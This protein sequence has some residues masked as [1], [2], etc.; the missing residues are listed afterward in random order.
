AGVRATIVMPSDAP[1][2]KR[3]RTEKSGARI[4][5]Y[6]REKDDRDAIARAIAEEDGATVIHAYDNAQVV[7]GQGTVGL[8]IAED[9]AALGV[10]P[11]IVLVNC[12]GGGLTA[13]IALAVSERFADAAIYTAEP[14]GFDDY[15]RSLEAGRIIANDRLSGSVCDAL[16]VS[17]PGRISFAINQRLAA[18][19]LAVS[20]E[21]A[22]EAVGFAYEQLRLIV[23]PGGAV[24]LAALLSGQ[25]EVAGKTVI[26]VLSGGNIDDAVLRQGIAAYRSKS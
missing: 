15:R 11:D 7:A 13:G 20:D 3:A 17:Q 19:G 24:A 2:A 8:E 5:T 16:L 23:E 9:C 10:K 12:S 21:A 14:Q 26:V 6:D 4:V 1:E 22:L 25:I 18:G